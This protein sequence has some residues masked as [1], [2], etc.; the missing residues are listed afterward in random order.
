MRKNIILDT[1]TYISGFVFQ[2]STVA[3]AVEKAQANFQMIFSEATWTELETVI[4]RP[5]FDKFLDSFSRLLILESLK[6]CTIFIEP[7]EIITDCRDPKD[8]KFLEIAI[9]AAAVFIVTGDNDLLVLNPYRGVE[10]LK[11]SDFLVL[12]LA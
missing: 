11:S 6:E 12:E 9:A 2:R 3:A 4:H 5:K 7:T 1:N 8:N 10:I